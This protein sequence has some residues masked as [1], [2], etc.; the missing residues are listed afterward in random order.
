M[1]NTRL[2]MRHSVRAHR[3]FGLVTISPHPAAFQLSPKSPLVSALQTPLGIS[4]KAT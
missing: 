3:L 4:G 1:G 2:Q